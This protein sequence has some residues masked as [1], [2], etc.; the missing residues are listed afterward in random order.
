M[1]YNS[2]KIIDRN[3]TKWVCQCEC[4]VVVQ[5]TRNDIVSGKSKRC[6]RCSSLARVGVPNLATKTHGF[7]NSPTMTSW[8]EMKRR[9]YAKHRQEYKNY[10]GR[11]ITVCQPWLDSFSNFLSDMGERLAGTT[12]ER[13][14]NNGSY[15]RE[16]CCWIE[17]R[18]QDYNKRTSKMVNI[19]GETMCLAQAC[20]KFDANYNKVYQRLH[21][22][23]SLD[24]ALSADAQPFI[25]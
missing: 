19:N 15:C 21:R 20:Q 22:G 24:R 4:G 12:L 14:D 9:C 3:G 16:N 10:G 18:K 8:A 2:W 7:G 11:G 5:R 23:W 17:R 1:K 6:R 25:G 13:I